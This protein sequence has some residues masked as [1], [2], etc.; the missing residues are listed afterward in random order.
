MD[1]MR[2]LHRNI[3]I[4]VGIAVAGYGLYLTDSL[5]DLLASLATELRPTPGS[6][7]IVAMRLY[8]ILG[9]IGAGML[10]AA[11]FRAAKPKADMQRPH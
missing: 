5:L 10:C 6:S 8:V 11:Y 1:W 9:G 4:W 7:L 2:D 3:A